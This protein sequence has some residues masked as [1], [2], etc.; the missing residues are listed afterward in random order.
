MS[1]KRSELGSR[2]SPVSFIVLFCCFARNDKIEK[3]MPVKHTAHS[4]MRRLM[5]CE[6]QINSRTVF[7]KCIV[8]CVHV[9]YSSSRFARSFEP[10]Q[11][12]MK[13]NIAA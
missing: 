13:E 8:I 4:H 7:T 3:V 1:I 11:R 12:A 9:D 2:D 6:C 5:H 10:M